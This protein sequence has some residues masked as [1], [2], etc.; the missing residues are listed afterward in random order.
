MYGFS[1][2]MKCFVV[3]RCGEYAAPLIIK[4]SFIVYLLNTLNVYAPG[5]S[6]ALTDLIISA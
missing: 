5:F 2:L 6:P 3:K 1:I 4:L